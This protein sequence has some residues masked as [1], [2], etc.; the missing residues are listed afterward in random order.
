MRLYTFSAGDDVKVS[1]GIGQDIWPDEVLAD[2]VK[3]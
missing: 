2:G 1:I 3:L